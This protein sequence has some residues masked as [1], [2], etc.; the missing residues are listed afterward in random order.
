MGLRKKFLKM[1]ERETGY[2]Q[3]GGN[4]PG[5]KKAKIFYEEP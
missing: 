3:D 5:E 1:G 2:F 4:D